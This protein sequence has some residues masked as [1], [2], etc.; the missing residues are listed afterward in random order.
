[1]WWNT[2][3]NRLSTMKPQSRHQIYMPDDGLIVP[4]PAYFY[5]PKM[6]IVDGLSSPLERK[7][8]DECF[9]HPTEKAYYLYEDKI[10]LNGFQGTARWMC[11]YFSYYPKVEDEKSGVR[12]PEWAHEALANYVGM[13]AMALDAVEDARYRQ[14]TA[15]PDAT[16]NPTH[17][18]YL[19]VAKY[20]EK[21]FYDIINSHVDD[22]PD[23][24]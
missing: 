20:Y 12:P 21:R 13:Q 19:E 9:V 2:A 18:P 6:V 24:R 11:S 10:F 4:L 1:M 23:F 16:G 5:K 15:P 14:Y 7:T 8:V 22:D 17:N 3:Q